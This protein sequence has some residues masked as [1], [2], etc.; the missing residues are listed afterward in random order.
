MK[1]YVTMG[2]HQNQAEVLQRPVV[3]LALPAAADEAVV[4]EA[5]KVASCDFGV[6]Q[7]VRPTGNECSDRQMSDAKRYFRSI[8]RA[9]RCRRD[10]GRRSDEQAVLQVGRK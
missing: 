9:T 1:S 8:S 7:T 10:V 5:D 2:L 6:S 4:L 3:E